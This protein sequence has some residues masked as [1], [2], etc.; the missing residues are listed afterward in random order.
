MENNALT[1]VVV[2]ASSGGLNPIRHLFNHVTN[3]KDKAFI[4]IQ[5]HSPDF[6]SSL[7]HIIS[8]ESELPV[9]EVEHKIALSPE[10]IY[11]CPPDASLCFHNGLLTTKPR[12]NNHPHSPIDD[13]LLSLNQENYTN[14]ISVILS[15]TGSDGAKGSQSIKQSGGIVLGL[16]PQECLYPGMVETLISSN[17]VDHVFKLDE[18]LT[19]INKHKS[20]S[21]DVCDDEVYHQFLDILNNYSGVDFSL[22]KKGTVCRRLLKRMQSKGI[23]DMSAYLDDIKNDSIER[24]QLYNDVFVNVTSFFRDP[25]A[26]LVL[27]NKVLAPLMQKK[28]FIKI[29]SCACATGEEAYSIAITIDYYLRRYGKSIDFKVFAT[30]I[31]QMAIESASRGV[32]SAKAIENVPFHLRSVYFQPYGKKYKV[33]SF[34]REK[35]VFA[36]HNILTDPP[37]SHS[38]MICCRNF[39]IYIQPD[40]QQSI[41][42]LFNNSLKNDGILFL[43][44]SESVG[45]LDGVFQLIDTRW[46]IYQNKHQSFS[47]T[48]YRFKSDIVNYKTDIIQKTT[49]SKDQMKLRSSNR[50]DF[51]TEKLLDQFAPRTIMVNDA[52]DIL[53]YRGDFDGIFSWPSDL[54]RLNLNHVL[55]EHHAELIKSGIYKVISGNKNLCLENVLLDLDKKENEVVDLMIRLLPETYNGSQVLLIAFIDKTAA[56]T[57]EVEY[58]AASNYDPESYIKDQVTFLQEELDTARTQLLEKTED[59]EASNEELQSTNEELLSSNEELQSTNEEMQSVNEELFVV[60]NEMQNKIKEITTLN[61]DID[62]LLRS[63]EIGTIFLDRELNIRKL[64]PAVTD[65]FNIRQSDVGRPLSHFTSQISEINL[66]PSAKKVINGA[67]M[68]QQEIS[69]NNGG[70]YLMRITPFLTEL[71]DNQGAV[72]TFVDV[73]KVKEQ[74]RKLELFEKYFSLNLDL[75]CIADMEGYFVHLNPKFEHVLGFTLEELKKHTIDHFVHPDDA[76]K[77]VKEIERIRYGGSSVNF[78]NRFVTKD[79]RI[80]QFLWTST[81][82]ESD[83]LIYAAARDMTVVKQLQE[84]NDRAVASLQESEQRFR[85][86]FNYASDHIVVVDNELKIIYLNHVRT[87]NIKD[88]IGVNITHYIQDDENKEITVNAIRKVFQSGDPSYYEIFHEYGD[89]KRYYNCTASPVIINSKVMA[90]T[91]IARDI[92]PEKKN[93]IEREFEYQVTLKMGRA[94]DYEEALE[95]LVTEIG[96]FIDFDYGEVWIPTQVSGE[97][98]LMPVTYTTGKKSQMYFDNSVNSFFSSGEGLPGRVYQSQQP[99]WVEDL[100][101]C[102]WYIRKDLARQAD[103]HTVFGVPVITDNEVIAV[104]SFYAHQKKAN[105]SYLLRFM[106]IMTSQVGEILKRKK[107]EQRI[108]TFSQSLEEKSSLLETILYTMHEGV[109][110]VDKS[111]KPI[112]V[113]P[114]AVRELGNLMLKSPEKWGNRH[115]FFDPETFGKIPEYKLPMNKALKGEEVQRVEL[116]VRHEGRK[117]GFYA[118]I[119]A[120]PLF[121]SMGQQIG[122]LLVFRDITDQKKAEQKLKQ[123]TIELERNNKEL[124]QFAYVAT[125]D[126]RAPIVNTKALIDL[127]KKRNLVDSKLSPLFGKVDVSVNRIYDTLH[128][129]ISIATT[130]K[131]YRDELR[132][133]DIKTIIHEVLESIE[134]QIREA[135]AEVNLSFDGE[136]TIYSVPGSLKS[137]T[138][139]LL[140]NAIK[141]RKPK[142][143]SIVNVSSYNEGDFFTIKVIDNGLGMDEHRKNDVFAMFKRLHTHSEGKGL[144]LYLT[145]MQVERLG[146]TIDFKSKVGEGSEFIVKLPNYYKN[147]D[148]E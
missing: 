52:F 63:T 138:Q 31:D 72:L 125:H 42:T 81:V 49:A 111:D 86:I 96:K 26:F 78:E 73:S 41:L 118:S 11:I 6:D 82:S 9:L 127:I 122:G 146:G 2:G 7:D 134:E 68:I 100:S 14:V 148:N 12:K 10:H 104:I 84:K 79:G 16:H 89:E 27:E 19:F 101:D 24:R 34:L 133:F 105:N 44:P 13:F 85:S 124:Q 137:I 50:P 144:G 58:I 121:D 35:M 65:I 3:A 80:V 99:L 23:H 120:K 4:V 115:G 126:L 20:R 91:V 103:F 114:A 140:T 39:L 55:K 8:N 129:L 48:P 5:H 43:G 33:K 108:K 51:F 36:R 90:V 98:H 128:D 143:K 130:K 45:D 141:Y 110:A 147:D 132:R 109:L 53:F 139:N 21:A 136:T 67:E 142:Q 74:E 112:V 70:H 62:N 119:T 40:V 94:E 25:T 102:G 69:T 46:K 29:W 38:D 47:T 66:I 17:A 93:I 54:S 88:H 145:K 116:F 28:D 95:I 15:G 92:T 97:L 113:N 37:F 30:D 107:V 131:D 61:D 75:L 77:T 123:Q 76:D 56:E 18:I 60:N 83:Q 87:G 117:N 106:R 1:I 57:E 71:K 64:T 135:K 59:L 32:Y 22:Y